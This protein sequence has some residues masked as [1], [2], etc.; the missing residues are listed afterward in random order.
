MPER[1]GL[2]WIQKHIGAFGGD[3]NKVTMYVVACCISVTALISSLN[4]NCS[5]GGS[6]GAL[7]V[8]SH[9]V[10]NGGD[11]EGLFRAAAMSCGSVLPTGDI[12]VQQQFF[13]T[14]A[15]YVGCSD[16]EDKLE[17]LRGVPAEDL[18]AAGA[19]I[20][21]NFGY[22]VRTTHPLLMVYTRL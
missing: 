4:M 7:S 8:A 21:H 18:V 22:K 20:P 11:N 6:A 19:T 2:R 9:M 10:A 5:W 12:A 13:D 3:P 14:I 16:A 17:C 1:E 15:A